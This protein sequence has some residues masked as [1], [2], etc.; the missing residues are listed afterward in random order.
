ME[1]L[2]DYRL[3]N[4]RSRGPWGRTD[5]SRLHGGDYG[6]VDAVPVKGKHVVYVQRSLDPI[7]PDVVDDDVV[8]DSVLSH[9]YHILG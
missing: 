9:R 5:R 7:L 1:F 2:D 8:T 4:N 6:F 3:P